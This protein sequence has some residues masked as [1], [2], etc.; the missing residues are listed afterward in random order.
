MPP[1][2]ATAAAA[3]GGT[4]VAAR[5]GV[6][7]AFDELAAALR[8]RYL[9]TF[10]RPEVLPVAAVVTA[11]TPEGPVTAD[12]VVPRLATAAGP[13]GVRRPRSNPGSRCGR[14]VAAG[15][16]RAGVGRDPARPAPGARRLERPESRRARCASRP[17][18]GGDARRGA[19][20][21]GRGAASR[22]RDNGPGHDV[23]DDRVRAPVARRVR[24]RL[25]GPGGGP[26]TCRRPAGGAGRDPRPGS[27]DR[28][29]RGGDGS[30]ARRAAAPGPLA[31]GPRRRREP[32]AAGP[33]PA[34]GARPRAGRVRRPVV[35]RA[36]HAGRR[37]AVRPGRVDRRAPVPPSGAVACPGG[38]G[39]VRAGRRAAGG[40]RRGRDARGDRDERRCL[41]ADAHR[42]V[43]RRG[44]GCDGVRDRPGPARHRRPGRVEPAGDAGL[45]GPRPRPA[46]PARR[47]VHGR[48]H[49]TDSPTWRRSCS[50]AGWPG[51]TTT[52]CSC[53]RPWPQ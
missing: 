37:G 17:A 4:A 25:V 6:I 26:A 46:V 18:A 21:R 23:R 42:A 8:T 15:G 3:T 49:R 45:P 22:R 13:T 16:G 41:P 19:G 47:S 11:D 9:V 31:V 1:Y 44:R 2:W 39:G 51:S 40:R 12:A 14:P 36:R 27:D 10:P 24:H 52:P 38:S 32:S 33:V 29:R 30:T 35:G 43:D 28:Q 34:R 48:R 7:A 20:R 50:G 5:S 53:T